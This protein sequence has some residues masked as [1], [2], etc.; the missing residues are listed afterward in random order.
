M[1]HTGTIV[2][3]DALR[4]RRSRKYT[5]ARARGSSR[6][7]AKRQGSAAVVQIEIATFEAHTGLQP[8]NRKKVGRR[9]LARVVKRRSRIF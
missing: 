9:E 8:R 6:R 2:N 3:E 4:E 5:R 7:G 1:L